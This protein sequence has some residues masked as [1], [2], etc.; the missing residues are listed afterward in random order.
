MRRMTHHLYVTDRRDANAVRNEV[1]ALIEFLEQRFDMDANTVHIA[2]HFAA[3][4]STSSC[5]LKDVH[6]LL[7][8]DLDASTLAFLVSIVI[9]HV[10][11]CMCVC[12]C[13]CHFAYTYFV[14]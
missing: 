1:I 4:E 12:V 6:N 14:R 8:A 13:V 3:L 2:K 5:V 9:T 11:R 7:G 10:S